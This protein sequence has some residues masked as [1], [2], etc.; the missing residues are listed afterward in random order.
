MIST[1]GLAALRIAATLTHSLPRVRARILAEERLLLDVAAP[2]SVAAP[3]LVREVSPCAFRGAVA[4]AHQATLAGERLSFLHLPAGTDVTIELDVPPCGVAR[5]GGI[6]RVPM[7]GRWMWATATTLDLDAA[8]ELARP[9]VETVTADLGAATLALR[10]DHGTGVTLACVETTAVPG[11]IA[12]EAIVE[13]LESLTA[14]WTAHELMATIGD[15]VD[16][17]GG[18]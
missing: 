16:A 1:T 6:Y 14:R 2:G 5:P 9:L 11:S 17:H 7:A 8:H 13:L 18:S 4:R 10:P 15:P 12:E 3:G